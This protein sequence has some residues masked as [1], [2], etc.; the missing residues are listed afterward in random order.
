MLNL[1]CVQHS[2]VSS[3]VKYGFHKHYIS[4]HMGSINRKRLPALS[5]YLSAHSFLINKYTYGAYVLGYT[6]FYTKTPRMPTSLRSSDFICSQRMCLHSSFSYIAVN[7]GHTSRR[8]YTRLNRLNVWQVH[9][10][11]S[12][13]VLKTFLFFM[14]DLQENKMKFKII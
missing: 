7:R 9:T 8:C 4:L 3:T 14:S 10:F 6:S 12:L 2:G 5:K 13:K 11:F 1:L